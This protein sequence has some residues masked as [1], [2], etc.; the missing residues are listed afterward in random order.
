VDPEHDG[1]TFP[2]RV[3]RRVDIEDVAF[4]TVVDVWNVARQPLRGGRAVEEKKRE[5]ECASQ[6]AIHGVDSL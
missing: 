5:K 1:Q 6:L 3:F 2:S 4:V